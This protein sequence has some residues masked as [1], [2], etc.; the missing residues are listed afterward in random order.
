MD[1]EGGEPT[2]LKGM[3]QLLATQNDIILV[4]EFNPDCLKQAKVH[5]IDFLKSIEHYGFIL[6]TI[7]QTGLKRIDAAKLLDCNS[8]VPNPNFVNLYCTKKAN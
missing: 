7:T 1:I 5:P 2:A 4:I 8:I 3:Q 6:F